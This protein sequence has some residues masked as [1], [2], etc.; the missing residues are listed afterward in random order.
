MTPQGWQRMDHIG[1]AEKF[2]QDAF[3][4]DDAAAITEILA[5]M[6]PWDVSGLMGRASSQRTA[7]LFRFLPEEH[8]AQVFEKLKPAVQRELIL[9]LDGQEASTLFAELDP[10]DRVRLLDELPIL[11]AERLMLGLSAEARDVTTSILDYPVRSV[12]H[13]MSPEYV[14]AHPQS[15][16]AETLETV[17]S[18]ADTAESIYVIP[19]TDDSHVLVGVVSLRDL[20][21]HGSQTTIAEILTP[22]ESVRA[23]AD[24]EIAARVCTELHL[25]AMPVVDE[26]TRLVGIFTLDDALVTLSDAETED[27]ARAGGT[28]P[29]RRPYLPTPILRV[30]RSRVV[31]LLVLAISAL[32]TVQVL[33]VFEATLEQKVVL[34]LFIPLLTGTGGNTG[35]QAATTVTRALAVGDVRSGDLARVLYKEVRVGAVLGLLLGL[36]GF[37]LASTFF[38]FPMGLVIGLTLLLICTMAATVGGAMPMLAR[39]IRVDPA[40]FSTPFITTF[41]DATGLVIYFTIAKA[42]LGI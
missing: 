19:V 22:A 12:G 6:G 38:D 34:A 20:I 33:G 40:V 42:V 1:Q 5:T 3:A 13:R 2:L 16:V 17:R 30:A 15:T 28:E 18:Q 39:S 26:N 21:A 10:D 37:A 35:S 14:N 23:D 9:S 7:E 32:L 29:L 8:T 41:C 4:R 11:L 36:L 31:W 27:M 24:A 25:L